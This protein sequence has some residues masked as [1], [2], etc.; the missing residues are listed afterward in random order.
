MPYQC[1][2][3]LLDPLSHSL[4]QLTEINDCIL[5]YT[6][7]SQAKLYYDANSIV[8][9]YDGVLSE[10]PGN[11]KWFWIFDST[12][13]HFKHF[14]QFNVAVELAKLISFKFSENLEKIIIINP[15]FYISSTYKLVYPFLNKKIKSIIEFNT[16]CKTSTDV[17][18]LFKLNER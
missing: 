1:P 13:F 12:D 9:H 11:K 6:C 4:T 18:K 10:I 5:F 14:S 15:T 17:I 16:I 8:K 3:C 7:P 2:L